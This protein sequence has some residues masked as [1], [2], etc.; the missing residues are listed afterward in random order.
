ME[1][2]TLL[3]SVARLLRKS[4]RALQL[5]TSVGRQARNTESEYAEMQLAEWRAINTELIKMLTPLIERTGNK[6]LSQELGNLVEQLR[7]KWRAS[8]TEL[9]ELQVRL[10]STAENGDFVRAAQ[11]SRDLVA[12][13]ARTQACQ[14]GF[15]EVEALSDKPASGA[16][17]AVGEASPVHKIVG[18]QVTMPAKVIPLRRISR[19]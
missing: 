7:E 4:K 6:N 13:K 10:V 8:Q 14:A 3:S 19:G 17:A 11:L 9:H 1:N 12:L 16:I 18:E 5:Y 2:D 15:Y